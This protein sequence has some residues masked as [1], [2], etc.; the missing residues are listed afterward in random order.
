MLCLACDS[1]LPYFYFGLGCFALVRKAVFAPAVQS[2]QEKLKCVG[3]SE[4]SL[5]AFVSVI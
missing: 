4:K 1:F 2:R 3:Y 5:G